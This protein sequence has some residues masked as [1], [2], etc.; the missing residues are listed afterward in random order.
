[1]FYFV[2]S[3]T[4]HE[5]TREHKELNSF[6][7]TMEEINTGICERCKQREITTIFNCGH[8]L[9]CQ[10]CSKWFINASCPYCEVTVIKTAETPFE[11][12]RY[13]VFIYLL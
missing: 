2:F 6:S 7:C 3:Y 5:K 13:Y 10:L 11:L 8:R 9:T 4:E 1:M 12:L